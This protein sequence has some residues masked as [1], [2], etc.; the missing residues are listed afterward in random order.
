MEHISS[1]SADEAWDYATV[2]YRNQNIIVQTLL[3]NFFNSIHSIVSHWSTDASVLEVG[4]GAG[5]SSIRLHKMLNVASFEA[6]EADERYVNRLKTLNLPYSISQE[7]IYEIKRQNDSIDHL[8]ALEVLE[9]LVNPDFALA[10]L[11]RV[12][13]KSILV[14][15]P[16]EPTWRILNFLRFKYVFQFGN[17]PGHI[18][19][20]SRSKLIK[21]LSKHGVVKVVKTP[22][23]WLVV[24]VEKRSS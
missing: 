6:S 13:R 11:M 10:E 19:H 23:P 22:L 1:H 18:N 20:F 21:L 5:E 9:H 2:E 12:C 4:C 7:S 16:N 24:E 3:N 15:V 14:S 8:I 17:T